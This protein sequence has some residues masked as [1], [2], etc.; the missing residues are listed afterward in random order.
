M[1]RSPTTNEERR[2][3]VYVTRSGG[4]KSVRRGDR[5]SGCEGASETGRWLE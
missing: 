2:E 5:E 1:Y 4:D 3:C